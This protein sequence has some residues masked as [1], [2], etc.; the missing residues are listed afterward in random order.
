MRMRMRHNISAVTR[1]A[2]N[3]A[4]N[5]RTPVIV[6]V[7][8]CLSALHAHVGRLGA[9]LGFFFVYWRVHQ[10]KKLDQIRARSIR[11][12]SPKTNSNGWHPAGRHKGEKPFR[13]A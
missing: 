9:W 10:T 11:S 5:G 12:V 13:A 6:C 1:A 3:G 8:V 2:Q 4:I 7:C